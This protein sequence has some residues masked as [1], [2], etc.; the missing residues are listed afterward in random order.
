[1]KR[2]T[3]IKQPV[4]RDVVSELEELLERARR[5]EIRNLCALFEIGGQTEL[6][7]RGEWDFRALHF[8]L[9]AA[10]LRTIGRAVESAM[11]QKPKG[12]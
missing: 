5:G 11:D 3:P 1:M 9:S 8:A 7:Q 12:K 4:D 2:P 6:A 10:A